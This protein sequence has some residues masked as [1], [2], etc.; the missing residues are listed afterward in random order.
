[1]AALVVVMLALGGQACAP[2]AGPVAV[3][4]SSQAR[5]EAT[6]V[7]RT[8]VA[9][10]QRIIANNP[11]PTSTPEPTALPRPSC[12]DALWWHEARSHVGESRLL[13]GNIVGTRP[14]PGGTL[15]LELGQPYPDP[16]GVAILI[17]AASAPGYVGKSV[18]VAGRIA[19][20]EGVPTIQLRDTSAIRV[21]DQ[22]P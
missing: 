12:P 14:A 8:A 20:L 4:E 9:A 3:D 6:N 16:T 15:L 18:C 10:A 13:Q 5:A 22:N 11:L 7:R 2:A 17:P 21:L 19:R 1:M